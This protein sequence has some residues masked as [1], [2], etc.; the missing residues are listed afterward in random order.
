[1]LLFSTILDINE[2][3]TKDDFIRL[4]IEWNQGSPYTNN[5]ISGIQWNGERNIRYG[6]DGLWLDIE[7]YRNQNIIAVRYEKKDDDGA[8][9]DTDYVMNFRTMKMSIRLD[10]SYTAE[11]LDADPNFSTPHFITLLIER[12]YLKDD[13]HLPV[14]KT[15]TVINDENM[16]MLVDVINGKNMFNLPVVYVSKTYNDED[17]VN[18]SYLSSRLKGVAH[19]MIEESN[20]LNRTI[21]EQ[22]K[23]NNEYYGAIGIYYPS[24]GSNHRRYL[25][26]SAVGY[27]RFLLERVVRSVIQYSNAQMID[28]LLT[29]QG[30]NN[31]LLRD[32]L[33]SQREERLAAEI[34]RTAAE[35]EAAK[36]QDS[37][38]EEER[39]IRKQAAEDARLEANRLLDSFDDEMQKLQNQVVAL[40]RANETLQFENQG[41]KAKLDSRD[42]IPV[43]FMGDEFEF[44]PG[45]VKDIILAILS[46]AAKGI[47]PKSR[48]ADIVRDIIKNNDYQKLSEA[49]AEEA[50]RILKNYDG[51]TAKTRQALKE[52]GFEITE[53]GKHYKVS[54]YGDGRYQTTYSKTPSDGRTGKNCAQT[55]INMAF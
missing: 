53:E 35:A 23:S 25:Y 50:K 15:A 27:D 12:G 7:E 33:T 2:T 29:W 1:M 22:C 26:R 14:Q 37:L 55:T 34:A 41:L 21:K 52:L 19:V 9:W 31:A 42:T 40:T 18:V 54:Y 44:Y 39:R 5:I 43:L 46:E 32:R 36:I 28:T 6:G 13:H 20:R 8:I 11:A 10:R 47:K 48:R 38:D 16:R 30:V 4:V 49:K 3:L 24:H 45:E 51:M 17:P